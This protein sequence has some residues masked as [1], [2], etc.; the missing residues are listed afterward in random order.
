[1]LL[2]SATAWMTC[3]IDN[4]VPAGDHLLVVL[5]VHELDS[6]PDSPLVFHGSVFHR[7]QP[8]EP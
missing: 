2:H 6:R 7:L 3:S 4:T 5:R 1:V 8:V